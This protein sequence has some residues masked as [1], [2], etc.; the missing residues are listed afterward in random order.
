MQ[1]QPPPEPPFGNPYSE[2]TQPISQPPGEP[3]QPISPPPPYPSEQVSVQPTQP[4]PQAPENTYGQPTPIQEQ[5]IP[6][7]P[8]APS[9]PAP[10]PPPQ[11]VSP[12]RA[13][14]VTFSQLR[15]HPLIDI[16]AGKTIGTVDDVLLDEH[17]R[18]IQAFLTK[19]GLFHKASLVPAVRA[20]IGADAV[21]FQPGALSGQDT[22]WLD[23]LP[24]A[25]QIIGMRVLTNTGQLL[26]TVDNLRIERESASLIALE[27]VPEQTGIAHRL[28]SVRRLLASD[29]II[30]YGPDT[31]VAMEA[32]VSEL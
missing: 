3:M 8:G 2:P 16:A 31:I 10:Q 14:W 25:S 9:M 20:T 4:V 26:G 11:S 1:Q 27:L 30:S 28:G 24:K 19:G 5:N 22:S 32:G 29:S 13:N 15:G 6:Q 23:T 7:A 17:R 21:T 12:G 18:A